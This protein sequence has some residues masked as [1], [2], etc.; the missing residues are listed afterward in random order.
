V[1]LSDLLPAQVSA[2][3]RTP[4][5]TILIGPSPSPGTVRVFEGA[6]V[7]GLLGSDLAAEV[8]IPQ[9]IVVHRAG[10]LITREEVVAAIQSALGHNGFPA[11]DIQVDDL[12]IFPSVMVSADHAD[13]RV[14]RMDFDEGLQAARFLMAERGALPFLVTAQLRGT[15]PALVASR[16]ILPGHILEPSDVHAESRSA[17]SLPFPAQSRLEEL[18]GQ[19]SLRHLESGTRVDANQLGAVTLVEPRNPAILYLSSSE[20]QMSLDV[21]PLEKGVLNQTIRVKLP[22]TGKVLQARVVGSR[23][24]EATF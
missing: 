21:T 4:A 16:D 13:L 17:A 8:S 1:F 14:R 11:S 18:I 12:R 7:A 19:R 9:Q 20:M 5:K 3:M 2:A 6:M 22:V 15:L 24:L 23:R 10:R